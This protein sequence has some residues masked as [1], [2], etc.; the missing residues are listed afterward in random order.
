MLLR[1]PTNFPHTV[2]QSAERA[3]GDIVERARAGDQVAMAIIAEVRANAKTGN[4]RASKSF[5]LISRYIKRNPPTRF[6]YL[7]SEALTKPT[8]S[9]N[10]AGVYDVIHSPEIT[11]LWTLAAVPV[12]QAA[13]ALTADLG[14]VTFWQGVCALVH[15]PNDVVQMALPEL[16]QGLTVGENMLAVSL[17]IRQLAD[18]SIPISSFCPV[19]AWEMGE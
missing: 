9:S 3:A 17:S 7:P 16:L 18:E 15:A 8:E 5:A 10:G 19:V 2:T 4:P 14:K 11:R 1:R 6:G 13:K 12:E